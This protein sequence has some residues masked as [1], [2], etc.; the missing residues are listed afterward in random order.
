MGDEGEGEGG[1]GGGAGSFILLVIPDIK[2]RVCVPPLNT[3]RGNA[4]DFGPP[5]Q[6]GAWRMQRPFASRR[7]KAKGGAAGQ[8]WHR[9]R[10]SLCY[11]HAAAINSITTAGLLKLMVL[12]M[13][14]NP[15]TE[16]WG[17]MAL[18]QFPMKIGY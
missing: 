9:A 6:D 7:G 2:H 1:W 5:L 15:C 3:R 14:R 17:R 13:L 18:M 12:L 11:R 10:Q 16:A 4:G 8:A